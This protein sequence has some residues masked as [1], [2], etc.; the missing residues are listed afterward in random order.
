LSYEFGGTNTPAN[1]FIV[2]A[3]YVDAT[4]GGEG[5]VKLR[6]AEFNFVFIDFLNPVA[7]PGTTPPVL[8]LSRTG[9]SAVVSWTNGAGFILQRSP[10]ISPASW[11]DVGTANPSAPITIGNSP[12]FFRVRKP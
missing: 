4:A 12:A 9:N 8:S 6:D 3:R 1:S 10:T 5:V 11:T 7:P 2:E